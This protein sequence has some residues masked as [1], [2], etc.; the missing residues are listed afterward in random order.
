[1]TPA[2]PRTGFNS[3]RLI[4]LLAQLNVVD[5]VDVA[6]SKQ[7]FA[8]RLSLWLDW[9]DAIS[10]SAVLDGAGGPM[11]P[12]SGAPPAG[13]AAVEETA[14]VRAALVKAIHADPAFTPGQAAVKP[15]PTTGATLPEVADFSACRRA[16]GA[17]QRAM[18]AHIG[19][20]RANVRAALA[21]LSPAL[22]RLAAL[23]AAMDNALGARERQLLATV[24]ALLERHFRRAGQS[25]APQG[26][27]ASC[28]KDMRTVLLAELEVRLQPVEGMIEAFCN[29]TSRR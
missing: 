9:T 27:L 8:G 7:T 23:D 28:C 21:G 6:D 1:M 16:Y 26:W 2:L 22:G 5:V 3:S 10:L 29:D 17:H 14:R 13:R 19:A 20:L 12:R 15:P 11:S 25:P 4:R 18:A 24:P